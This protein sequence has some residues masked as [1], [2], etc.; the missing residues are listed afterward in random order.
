MWTDEQI[1]KY[2]RT[3]GYPEYVPGYIERRYVID[4]AFLRVMENPD[5]T[6]EEREAACAAYDAQKMDLYDCA[7][8][9][10]L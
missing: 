3:A 8:K 5:S 4:R 2:R 1:E 6:G 9:R 10:S 7:C